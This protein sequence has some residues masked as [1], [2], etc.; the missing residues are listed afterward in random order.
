M[1]VTKV[2]Q[3]PPQDRDLPGKTL[4]KH[5]TASWKLLRFI[6]V[7]FHLSQL[8]RVLRFRK[9]QPHR[10]TVQMLSRAEAEG[11]AILKVAS[12]ETILS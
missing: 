4:L 11:T 1:K 9:Q 10:P 12:S 3:T 8:L 7:P 6:S 2:V 5:Y